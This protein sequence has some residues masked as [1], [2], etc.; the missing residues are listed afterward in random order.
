[1]GR[2]LPVFAIRFGQDPYGFIG[3][4]QG[5]TGGGKTVQA[6]ARELFDSYRK[7]KQSQKRMA[8]VLVSL[9]EDSESFAS[10]KARIGYL[11]E[12]EVSEPSYSSRIEA[13]V[14]SNSQI[15]GSWGVAERVEQLAKK[16]SSA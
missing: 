1:M 14:E 12:L 13:A 7:N 2:G 8:E 3:R 11:E 9:F 15:S 4:F 5:F 10:A 16:W 6:L